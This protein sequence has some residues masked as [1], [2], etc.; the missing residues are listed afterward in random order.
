[1][2]KLLTIL[3]I[4]I[5]VAILA[6]LFG[7]VLISKY[8]E[9]DTVTTSQPQTTKTFNLKSYGFSLTYPKTFIATTTARAGSYLYPGNWSAIE[10]NDKGSLVLRLLVPGSN[11]VLT[12]ELRVGGSDIGPNVTT[13][14][15][16]KENYTMSTTTINGHFY[17][18]FSGS[19]AGMSHFGSVK[20]YRTVKNDTCLAIEELVYGTNGQ[21]YD[22]PRQAPFSEDAVWSMLDA[23]VNS[24]QFKN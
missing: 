2:K 19:D 21:V 24:A 12:G 15:Q 22:P 14:M 11:E 3:G 7:N 10:S 13:C 20:S 4:V 23:I 6:S 9:V 16:P 17:K 8:V 5:V 1:M 18:V